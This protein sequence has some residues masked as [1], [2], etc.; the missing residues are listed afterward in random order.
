MI[1]IFCALKEEASC[2]NSMLNDDCTVVITGVGK[3]NAAYSVGKV[4]GDKTRFDCAN[5]YVVNFGCACSS[6]MSGAYI[7]NKVT[8]ISTNRDF[9]P[10]M[11]RV[12]GLNEASLYT[13][14]VVVLNPVDNRLYDM[15][16]SAFY[17]SVSKHIS[18]DRIFL[19]KCVSDSGIEEKVSKESVITACKSGADYVKRIIDLYTPDCVLN[20]EFNA[21]SRLYLTSTIETQLNELTAFSISMGVDINSLFE[22]YIGDRNK[23]NKRETM[24][25]IDRV[26]Q[27]LIS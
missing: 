16:G 17:A 18:P 12:T 24:E 25:V 15:E 21:K 3:V 1:Y 5:D 7:I 19:I 6:N 26:R 10:D 11:I 14:D 2:L 22:E 27:Y 13:S 20:Y 23:L 9:Y 8:D 4:F